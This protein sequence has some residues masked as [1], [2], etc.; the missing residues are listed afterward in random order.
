MEARRL[1]PLLGR[2]QPYPFEKLRALL[3]GV[4][5]NAALRPINLSIGEPKHA[6]P[7]LVR[8][9][10]AG[11]LDGLAAYPATAGTPALREAVAAW[12]A[13]R[14]ALTS[15]DA[16]TQ[17]L[18]VN[19]SR[20]ALFAFAQTVIDPAGGTA[21][22][23][24]PN[25]FY[26]IYEGAALLAGAAPAYL[27]DG[28]EFEALDW[29]GV[30]L[31]YVCSPGNPTGRVLGLD[32]W[33]RLFALADRH[34]FIIAAD[35]CYSELYYDELHPPLGAL[36]AAQQLGRGDFA[37]VV[38]FSSLSKRSNAPGMRSGFVAG[39]AAL[40]QRFL[41]Y[42]T[43]H[44]SAMSL[45]VQQASI[46]AWRDEA[47]VRANRLLYAQKYRA[48]LPLVGAPLHTAMPDGGF[49][50][51]LRTPI[52]DAEFTR[53]LHAEYNVL[54]LPGSYLARDAGGVN[55]GRNRVRIALV[56]PLAECVEAIRRIAQLMKNVS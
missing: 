45:P 2:L 34:G 8:A 25:P 27:N 33:T 15:I 31:A 17:V 19:G 18:P 16:A 41:L 10:L 56:A 35:E 48:V 1:N 43:Y 54:V 4:T 32:A 9:A 22:V 6:T 3:A 36:Q 13:R 5:P 11:S 37:R 49:Y 12:L 47:H 29:R 46:A 51:W 30:Q 23:A 38:A 42:R 24:C 50:L 26:Q 52:D 40:L 53:R 20:E 21:R 55:P 14:Y 7:E 39:D 28:M 44:G